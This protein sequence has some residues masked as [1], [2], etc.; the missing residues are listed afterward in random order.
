M[1]S[2][3]SKST[4]RS[5]FIQVYWYLNTDKGKY[6]DLI[7]VD[8]KKAF[9]TVDVEHSMISNGTTMSYTDWL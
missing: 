8:L 1:N 2:E 6:I 5:L 4:W 7:L 3:T 9:D